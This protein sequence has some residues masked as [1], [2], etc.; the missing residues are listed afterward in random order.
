M[1]KK[2]IRN[3]RTNQKKSVEIIKI[4]N[5][6]LSGELE[7]EFESD[8][9]EDKIESTTNIIKFKKNHSLGIGDK[10]LASITQ[11]NQSESSI[12]YYE[13]ELISRIRT[14]KITVCGILKI[15]KNKRFILPINKKHKKLSVSLEEK[16]S[17]VD[18]DFVEAEIIKA[19]NNSTENQCRIIKILGNNF[20]GN[21]PSLMAIYE[22]EIPYAFSDD[23]LSEAHKVSK[24]K[25][26]KHLE[27]L[28]E[29]PF[30][31][32][33]PKDARDHDDAIYAIPDQNSDNKSGM[34]LWV[35]I[36][37]VTFYLDSNSLLDDEA[38]KRG[39]STYFENMAVP[40]IPELLS[41]EVCSLKKG[42]IRP[43]LI[44]KIILNHEGHKIDHEFI[45]GKIKIFESLSYED[46]QTMHES[47]DVKDFKLKEILDNIWTL[48]LLLENSEKED[49]SLALDLE[50]RKINVSKDGHIESI[51]IIEK[52]YS[53]KVIERCM[54]LANCCAAQTLEEKNEKF[55]YR[56][57]E[58][59]KKEKIN[60]LQNI[61]RSVGLR[62]NFNLN[63]KASDL[64][65]LQKTANETIH[66]QLISLNILKTMSQA[67]YT[68]KNKG[69]F[70]LSLKAYTH[71]TSPIRRYADII[72]HRA[73][74]TA[75]KW[76]KDDICSLTSF[77]M[78]KIGEHI[79]G[80]E[81]RSVVAERDS[82]DRYFAI[83]LERDIGSQF[84]AK[85]INATKF[86]LFI[87]LN[88]TGADGFIPVRSI[89]GDHFRFNKITNQLIGRNSKV[90]LTIGVQVLVKLK[91]VNPL[92][93]SLIFDLL[94]VN[95]KII[96]FNRKLI[97]KQNIRTNKQ[98]RKKKLN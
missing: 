59:P 62:F 52:L 38:L 75:H 10:L 83:Y 31:T 8:S 58:P 85:I 73:L 48:T 46:A 33:D 94:E 61:S 26:E 51:E 76:K 4:K 81:R 90:S 78:Q 20:I 63:L 22:H 54:V 47:S 29:I 74:I 30:I 50:E 64:N 97:R 65:Q 23:V 24:K 2:F 35:A 87:K 57:H 19:K 6:N 13:A 16:S 93:G 34:I 7:A 98:Y 67:H 89:E 27:D 37:D 86:G 9:S 41:N 5:V 96:Q 79:S 42:K 72:V 55:L 15:N 84:F 49:A 66:S 91:E 14:E 39:N 82:R 77:E 56:V 12:N 71:F 17:A 68:N 44:V 36:A 1:K 40:M 69:H 32:I 21:L 80:T 28:T 18:G 88:E 43:S 53:H 11:I 92:T 25:L 3:A 70:G 95:G 45:R 60:L